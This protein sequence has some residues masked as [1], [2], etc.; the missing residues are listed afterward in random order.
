MNCEQSEMWMME[1]LDGV[2]SAPDH[3]QLTLHLETCSHCCVEWGAL[4]ALDTLLVHPVLM[5]PAPGFVG[6]VQAR[7]DHFEAQR[8][9]LL[10]GLILMG[11]AMA[12]CL[13]AVPSLLGGRNPIEAYGAFLRGVYDLSGYIILLSYKLAL[14]LWLILDVLAK[15][16]GIP[17]VTMLTYVVGAIMAALAWRR[18]LTSQR[19][20][21]PTMR[22]GS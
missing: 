17:L 14:A 10:G 13:L 8:R 12:I 9:T 1:A 21:A 11:A 22:R 15:G 3:Q 19:G 16:A 4:N 18:S 6:R 7:V 20:A 5:S 2:L